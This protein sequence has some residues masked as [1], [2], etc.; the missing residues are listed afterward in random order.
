MNKYTRIKQEQARQERESEDKQRLS[1]ALKAVKISPLMATS[2][3]EI[4]ALE[5]YYQSLVELRSEMQAQYGKVRELITI[6]LE[7]S[8]TVEQIA[9]LR[10]E[11]LKP[12]PERL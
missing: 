3:Q 1:R 8:H 4:A 9:R 12:E 5:T 10:V 6:D 2:A 11:Q 7:L